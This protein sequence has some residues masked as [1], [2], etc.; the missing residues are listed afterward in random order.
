MRQPA[1][2]E[3]AVADPATLAVDVAPVFEEEV[4]GACVDC[5]SAIA[6]ARERALPGVVRCVGCQ[7]ELEARRP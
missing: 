1:L 4:G 2:D 5:G 3:V 7:L 6:A